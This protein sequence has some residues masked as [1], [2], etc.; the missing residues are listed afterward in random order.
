[1]SFG[2]VPGLIRQGASHGPFARHLAVVT[3]WEN[4]MTVRPPSS[5]RGVSRRLTRVVTWLLRIAL[6][7]LFLGAGFSKL[8]G[9]PE[10]VD[11]FTTIGAGQ[12]L[13]YVVGT[14]EVAGAIAVVVPRLSVLAAGALA[15]LMIGATVA[16]VAVL[17][18]S[19]ALT[20]AVFVVAALVVW[21]GRG[22]F[23]VRTSPRVQPRAE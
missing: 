18:A 10:M 20:L 14:C 7:G 17:H 16:N 22:R 4:P 19:P 11:M 15:L 2:L 13:R 12:W 21:L 5:D 6:A 1:M 23:G 8:A 3:S 9:Q